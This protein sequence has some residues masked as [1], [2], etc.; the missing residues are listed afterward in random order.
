ML[1]DKLAD[2]AKLRSLGKEKQSMEAGQGGRGG[3]AVSARQEP[4]REFLEAESDGH[5]FLGLQLL[6]NPPL[7][8]S[9]LS[10]ALMALSWGAVT[11]GWALPPSSL[12]LL[13]APLPTSLCSLRHPTQSLSLPPSPIGPSPASS[14]GSY[15]G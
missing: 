7:R 9:S 12:S 10:M 1:R 5:P 11:G 6:G 4:H 8:C 15:A 14:L 2:S 13:S 3:R